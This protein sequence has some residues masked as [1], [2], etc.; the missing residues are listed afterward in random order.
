[1]NIIYNI[2]MALCFLF[3]IYFGITGLFAFKKRKRKYTS[4]KMHKFAILIPCRNE[5]FVIADLIKSIKNLDYPKDLYTCYTIPNNC[6][7]NTKEIAEKENSKIIEIKEKISTKGEALK[8]AFGYLKEQDYDAY[9]IFDADNIVDKNFLKA[10]NDTLNEGY[11]VAQGFRDSKNPSDNYLTGSYTMFYYLQNIFYNEARMVLKRSAAIN[12][13]GF[14]VKKEVIDQYGFDTKT[15]T[16]DSEFTG[17][18]ALNNIRIAFAKEAITYDEHPTEFKVSWRQRKRWSSGSFDCLN[19]YGTSLFKNFWKTGSFSS[20]DCLLYYLAPLIQVISFVL[21]LLLGISILFR[22][23][24]NL[25]SLYFFLIC[26]ILNIFL[27]IFTIKLLKKKIKD[28]YKG[29]FGFPIFILTW[30]PI[31][32]ICLFKRTKKWE[33]IKHT[34]KGYTENILN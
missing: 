13:T 22:G 31:N 26:Y 14:C 27:N 24:I 33:P 32:T 11:L 29:I 28:H 6:T 9:V 7:D 15:L 5:E 17:L 34:K 8:Y 20:F 2:V 4:N 19:N 3:S 18:C 10:M 21:P 12:G 23:I 16:E 1:M 25:S 30:I